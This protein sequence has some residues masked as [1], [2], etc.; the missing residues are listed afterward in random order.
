MG[1]KVSVGEAVVVSVGEV[2]VVS[3]RVV[4]LARVV[5]VMANVMVAEVEMQVV[6][7]ARPDSTHR[8]RRPCAT[9]RRRGT[10]R[11]T[12]SSAGI[13]QRRSCGRGRRSLGMVVG[14]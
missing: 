6:M 4:V 2:V 8:A 10:T 1:G 3:A 5:V 9:A 14:E 7:A 12:T 13:R 11:H